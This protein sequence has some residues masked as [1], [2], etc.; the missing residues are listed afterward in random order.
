M[1]R[2]PDTPQAETST[3]VETDPWLQPRLPP[4]RSLAPLPSQPARLPAWPPHSYVTH[5]QNQAT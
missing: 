5:H 1:L 4:S 2:R 3:F